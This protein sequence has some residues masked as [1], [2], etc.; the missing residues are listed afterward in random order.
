MDLQEVG[1]GHGLE[2]Y[3]P[4]QGQIASTCECV[5]KISCFIKFGEIRD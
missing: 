3:G 2:L 1:F 5:N 4:E